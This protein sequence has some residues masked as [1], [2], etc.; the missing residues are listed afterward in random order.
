MP[1]RVAAP[2]PP[3]PKPVVR[4]DWR[5]VGRRLVH[6]PFL[7]I[8]GVSLGQSLLFASNGHWIHAI[9]A[10]MGTFLWVAVGVATVRACRK[11]HV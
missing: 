9:L 11:V 4:T 7:S 10:G 1:Y 5:E 8:L 2:P 6:S 3:E